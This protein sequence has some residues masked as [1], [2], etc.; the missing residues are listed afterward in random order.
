MKKRDT[1][2]IDKFKTGKLPHEFLS[3]MFKNYID[4][5]EIKD[6]RVIIGSKIGEDA[7]VIDME[8]RY[9]VVKTDPITFATKQ[10]AYYVVNVNV[11]DVVCTGAIP[12]W[13]QVTL[14]LPEKD[15]TK[16][17]V[18]EIFKELHDVCEEMNISIVGG[19]T[20]VTAGLNKPIVVG[21]LIGEVEK[22]SLVF[23]SGAEPGDAL[24]L[25]KGI[26]IEGTSIIA[27]EK[28]DFLLGKGLNYKFLEKCKNFLF[29]PGISV[30]KEALLASKN[31]TIKSMHDPTE[32]GLATGIA[33][34][35]RASNSGVIIDKSKIII[36]PESLELCKFYNLNPLN[37]LASGALLIA[38]DDNE[39]SSLID[40]LKNNNI[41]AAKIGRFVPK[42]KGLKIKNEKD[43]ISELSYSERDEITKIFE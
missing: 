31:F 8:D 39:S 16:E 4:D 37:T 11:N 36:F 42:E 40:L 19:H 30:K 38:I 1:N 25:T 28:E 23:T 34:I 29:D 20:E 43:E 10:I 3:N 17:L 12:K 9:L 35:C 2:Y 41:P 18:R 24:I 7:A 27:R 5:L 22:D 15:T 32:G 21:N 14:L 33:E 26:F 6:K 13:F